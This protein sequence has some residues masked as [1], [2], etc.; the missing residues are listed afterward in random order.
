MTDALPHALPAVPPAAA[1]AAVPV[2]LPDDALMQPLLQAARV[3]RRQAHA[4][5]SNFA[6]GAAL[7]DEHGRIHAGCNVENAA[8][9]QGQ[10]AEATAIGAL[11]MAGGRRIVA[12]V[13]VGVA[14]AP[15]TP[16]G[17]CRQ[18]LREFAGDDCTI[19]AADEHS[20]RGRYTLGQL[21]PHSFGPDHLTT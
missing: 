15:V 10:C 21:L 3:A 11:V 1:P 16:C 2:T 12:A 18:R 14:D 5:Y 6:V 9:P 17:G 7:L 4:P 19:W 8:Y 20:V 13:V